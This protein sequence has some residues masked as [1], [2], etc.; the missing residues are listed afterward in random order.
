V[1]FVTNPGGIVY[2]PAVK[3]FDWRPADIGGV[4]RADIEQCAMANPDRLVALPPLNRH[5]GWRAHDT[6]PRET[7]EDFDRAMCSGQEYKV[8]FN[9][10]GNEDNP[11]FVVD[12]VGNTL[13]G[14]AVYTFQTSQFHVVPGSGFPTDNLR[15]GACDDYAIRFS[16]K[17]DVSPENLDKIQLYRVSC[18]Q[19]EDGGPRTCEWAPPRERC[20]RDSDG[21]GEPDLEGECCQPISDAPPFFAPVAGGLGCAETSAELNARKQAGDE[22]ARPCLTADVGEQDEGELGLRIDSTEFD[23]VLVEKQVYRMVIPAAATFED[24]AADPAV[25]DAVFWDVCGMP[26]VTAD[27]TPYTYEFQIDE[28]KCKEDPDNDGTPFSCDNADD[29]FNPTQA[30]IDGDSVGDVW[31]L[32]PVLG[33]DPGN[34]ADSDRDGV[35]NDCDNCRQTLDQYN[36]G[37][38]LA[39]IPAYLQVRNIPFQD[40]TDDDGIGDV[41]DNCVWTPNCESYGNESPLVPYRVGDPIAYGNDDVCQ[42]DTNGDFVGD[43]CAGMQRPGA[44]GAIGF[45]NDD[46]FDQD[47]ITN[48]L[49][50]CPRQPIADRIECATSDQCPAGRTCADGLC[51]HLDSEQP[52]GDGV[53]DECD[54]CPFSANPN[55]ILEGGMQDDDKDGDFV[56]VACETTP[57][58]D[59]RQDPL[60]LAFFP[61]RADQFCCTT[62]LVAAQM[63][64][65]DPLTEVRPDVA[66]GD[67][68][69]AGTCDSS[70]EIH[71]GSCTPLR[72]PHPDSFV[73]TLPVRT[74]ELCSQE[75]VDGVWACRQLPSPV[76]SRPGILV[77]PPGCDEA[78]ATA[79]ITALENLLAPLTHEDF[80][81]D[82]DPFDALWQN[83]CFLPQFDQDYD[84]LGDSCDLCPFAFDPENKQFLDEDTG[85]LHPTFGAYCHGDYE[86][87]NICD[88]VG[89]PDEGEDESG[90]SESG[91]GSGSSGGGSGGGSTGG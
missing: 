57:S 63:D 34:S 67:L 47:G 42:Q 73:E 86:P 28:P 36:D 21:D 29:H 65:D 38:S 49:D 81:A 74:A 2:D 50:G 26:L 44:A 76:A 52:T 35:G 77:P 23:Q 53:G 32:C 55:Q 79:G 24:A 60:P 6:D 58:C 61:V 31:D 9:E 40:D 48:M 11:A 51:N 88:A 72:A 3:G 17:Y 15:I 71:G 22:C 18:T 16:N 4:S 19:P 8:M 27:A 43:A 80:E 91:G 70:D 90:G 37:A 30:D 56:G 46:D 82:P 1:K 68:L 69:L 39:G 59:D 62:Q 54:T 25:Y 89:R 14:K 75:Q 45:G 10:P 85:R 12:K 33:G 78:L 13:A 7:E 5:D 64:W 41:C 83:L 87:D 66:E 20:D 84:G